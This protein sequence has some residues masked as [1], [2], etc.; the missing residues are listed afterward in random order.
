MEILVPTHDLR[1]LRAQVAERRRNPTPSPI[2]GLRF[3][4]LVKYRGLMWVLF[5]H[6]AKGNGSTPTLVEYPT[7][8]SVVRD[9]SWSDI[10]RL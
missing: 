3:G 2:A 5:D 8:S 4:G 10:V 7:C 9:I 6:D 1:E